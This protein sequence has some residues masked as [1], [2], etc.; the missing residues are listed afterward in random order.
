MSKANFSLVFP[1]VAGYS[2]RKVPRMMIVTSNRG[3]VVAPV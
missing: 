1:A 3:A 2:L